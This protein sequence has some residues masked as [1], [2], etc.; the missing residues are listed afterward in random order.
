M[1][2]THGQATNDIRAPSRER[3]DGWAW[4]PQQRGRKVYAVAGI[5]DA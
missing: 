5:F 2:Q 3:H 4:P 1:E